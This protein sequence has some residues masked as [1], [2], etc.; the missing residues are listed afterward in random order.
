M[1][2]HKD[3]QEAILPAHTFNCQCGLSLCNSCLALV[4][5][6]II[7]LQLHDLELCWMLIPLDLVLVRGLDGCVALEPF[8]NLWRRLEVT[9]Q[10]DRMTFQSCFILQLP[11][12]LYMVICK[13]GLEEKKG[14]VQLEEEQSFLYAFHSIN[15][16][17][18][19]V[20]NGSVKIKQMIICRE[21]YWLYFY[22][23]ILYIIY[24]M[25]SP[26]L[27]L[28]LLNCSQLRILI[29]LRVSWRHNKDFR[30][31]MET[32]TLGTTED[33]KPGSFVPDQINDELH[34]I[35]VL[36]NLNLSC[37]EIH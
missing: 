2:S 31:W 28:C 22:K 11:G 13:A 6:S 37:S 12:D 16:L 33:K 14:W 29:K 15:F 35:H 36:P 17:C 32:L 25:H 26:V 8:H 4:H 7:R 24:Q 19:H 23:I 27:I 3:M 34:E 1:L 9:G 18:A 5:T 20:H 10:D 30:M 21:C